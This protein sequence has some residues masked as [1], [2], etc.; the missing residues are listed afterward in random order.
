MEMIHSYHCEINNMIF[1]E[2]IH[3]LILLVQ[4]GSGIDLIHLIS[5]CLGF[6]V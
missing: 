1:V 4:E 5:E 3:P 2:F 6:D